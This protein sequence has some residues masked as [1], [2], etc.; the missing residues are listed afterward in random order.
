MRL[1]RRTMPATVL[2]MQQIPTIGGTYAKRQMRP[3]IAPR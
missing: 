2:R 1:K 3:E